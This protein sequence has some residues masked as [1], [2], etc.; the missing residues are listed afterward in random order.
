MKMSYREINCYEILRI[1][2]TVS[3]LREQ[4]IVKGHVAT[5]RMVR[6][7]VLRGDEARAACWLQVCKMFTLG[8][9]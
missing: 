4:T 9:F 3:A 2:I 8:H 5:K 7:L 1:R 6:F